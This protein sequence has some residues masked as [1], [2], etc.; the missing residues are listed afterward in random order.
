MIKKRTTAVRP[1]EQ[2]LTRRRLAALNIEY[3]IERRNG[4]QG[5]VQT[6]LVTLVA[7]C[8]FIPHW[9]VA[10]QARSAPGKLA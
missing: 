3:E 8:I 2:E 4:A 5:L 6:I 9:L 7:I 10:R 1:P